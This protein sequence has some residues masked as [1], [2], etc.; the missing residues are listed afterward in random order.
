MRREPE[1]LDEVIERCA[2]G[3]EMGATIEVLQGDCFVVVN[4]RGE[5]WDGEYWVASW[6]DGVQFRRPDPAFELCEEL[7]REAEE[8]SGEAG[9]VC[10][11]VPGT[12]MTFALVPF[13]DLSQTD[14]RDFARKP[15]RC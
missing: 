8:L 5:C 2:L 10:Y 15:E 11:I 3:S 12:P 6:T 1:T 7:A 4:R 13:T 9:V 14:L